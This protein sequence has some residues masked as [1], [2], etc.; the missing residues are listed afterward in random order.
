[1]PKIIPEVTDEEA[2]GKNASRGG[3]RSSP[4]GLRRWLPWIVAALLML[5]VAWGIFLIV[6]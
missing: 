1:M 2:L 3:A 4:G 6:P 5:S